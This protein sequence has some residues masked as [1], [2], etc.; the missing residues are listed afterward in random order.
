MNTQENELFNG[1]LTEAT[2][3][4]CY[5]RLGSTHDAEDLSQEILLE[6]IVS[7]RL[8]CDKGAPPVAF[9]P[10]YWGLAR[11]RL[12]LFYRSRK[13]QAILLGETVGN[14][15]DTEPYYFDLCDIDEAI[16]AEVER[17]KLTY[18][19]SM[20][21]RIQRE[22]VVLYYLGQKSVKEIA[23]FL[24]IPE[25]TVKTRL[26]DARKNVKKGMEKSME[27]N[28]NYTENTESKNK[29]LSYAPASLNKSG[30][31]T[32][33]DHWDFLG[34]M[35]VEQIIAVCAY[36]GKTVRQIAEAIGVAPVYFEEKIHY[37][38]EHKFLKETAPGIYIDDFCVFPEQAFLDYSVAQNRV[39]IGRMAEV[40][41]TVKAL[42]PEIRKYIANEADL[43]DGYISWFLYVLAAEGMENAMLRRYRE[44]CPRDVP[45]NNG[46]DWRLLV[47]VRYPDDNPIQRGEYKGVAWSNIHKVFKTAHGA[48]TLA[49]LFQLYPFEARDDIVTEGNADL[50]MRLY[51]DPRL[52]MN[53]FEQ[54]Q[55]AHLISKG[56]LI[57]RDGGLF[58]NLPVLAYKEVDDVVGIFEKALDALSAELVAELVKVSDEHLLP[59]VRPELMEEY[60]NYVMSLS[61]FCVGELFWHAFNEGHDLEMPADY[62]ASAAGMA[63]YIR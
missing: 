10:W 47:R 54:E 59:Y 38:L 8:A 34:D 18:Q 42:L 11:N 28:A 29:R 50:L 63:V 48:F 30:C 16:V 56:F 27:S 53:E 33:T 49:N 40:A 55:A 41:A 13:K 45:A 58:L 4:W 44:D 21:S 43:S 61:F 9:Y 31:Y 5:R 62:A 1:E 60:V 37:L 6:A 3:L 36:E 7:Y 15:S 24:G 46:K 35:M 25:G 20:L 51:R 39:F 57:A 2:Y 23:E 14:P 12:R 26:F 32:I 52:A 19:L 22:C 17:Q